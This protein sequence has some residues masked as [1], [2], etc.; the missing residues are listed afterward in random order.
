VAEILPRIKS[1]R[2]LEKTIKAMQAGS[3]QIKVATV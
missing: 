2:E 1:R 3:M